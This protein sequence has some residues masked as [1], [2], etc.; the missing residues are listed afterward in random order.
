[1]SQ[2][3]LSTRR[4]LLR[5]SL[6]ELRPRWLRVVPNLTLH[7]ARSTL[8]QHGLIAPALRHRHLRPISVALQLTR[9]CNYRCMFCTVNDLVSD[10]D[11]TSAVTLVDFR[12]LLGR[13]LL[14]RCVRLSLTGG[15][16]MLAPDVFAIIREAKRRIPVVT[17][18]TNFSLIKRQVDAVNDSGLDMINISLYAPNELLVRKFSPK[19]SPRIYKRLSFVV[20][21]RDRYHHFARIP[22]VAQLAVDLGFQALYLQNYLPPSDLDRSSPRLENQTSLSALRTYDESFEAIRADVERR[23]A[24]LL[25]IAWPSLPGGDDGV[26]RCRQPD[27]QILIDP[28]GSLAPCC[29]LDPAP[30]FGNVHSPE[31]WSSDAMASVRR[32]LKVRGAPLDAGCRNCPFLSKDMFDA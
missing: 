27:T 2:V 14:S 25:A 29:I 1:M 24:P 8:E 12:R 30:R 9:H 31:D 17:M 5:K 18:N 20:N 21:P 7:W 6:R 32:G 13:P 15:E 23:F 26:R 10:G 4:F 22:E 28:D 19:L 3:Y 11:G 16:P